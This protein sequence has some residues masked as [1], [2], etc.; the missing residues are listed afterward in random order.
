MEPAG[1]VQGTW[2][3]GV[4]ACKDSNGWNICVV[5]GPKAAAELPGGIDGVLARI[6]G[7]GTDPVGVLSGRVRCGGRSRYRRTSSRAAASVNP[8]R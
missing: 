6:Q 3:W 5:T 7:L 1:T 2:T 8:Q 4:S